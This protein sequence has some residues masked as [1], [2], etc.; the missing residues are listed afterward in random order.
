MQRL[1]A[2]ADRCGEDEPREEQRD[3][4]PEL[5][6]RQRERDD[7]D[8]DERADCGLAS[9]FSHDASTVDADFT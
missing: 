7:R 4:E 9:D 2:G 3:H 1:D 8:H 5:P 6:E